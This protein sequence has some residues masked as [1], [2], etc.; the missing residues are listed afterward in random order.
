M[1][2]KEILDCIKESGFDIAFIHD[3]DIQILRREGTK[4]W[5]QLKLDGKTFLVEYN[6]KSRSAIDSKENFTQTGTFS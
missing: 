2:D 4:L 5:C 1:V 6:E 3:P